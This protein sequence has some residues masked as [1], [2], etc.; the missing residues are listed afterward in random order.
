MTWFILL[1]FQTA[2]QSHSNPVY[3]SL[4]DHGM[5]EEA[6]DHLNSYPTKNMNEDDLLLFNLNK[7]EL[8]RMLG[9]RDSAA[10]YLHLGYSKLPP[11]ASKTK[12]NYL[13]ELCKLNRDHYNFKEAKKYGYE[14]L[15]LLPTLNDSSIYY[16][17]LMTFG[18]VF[19]YEGLL[20]STLVYYLKAEEHINEKNYE[21]RAILA[22]NLGNLLAEQEAYKSSF[23]KFSEAENLFS[24]ADN[25]VKKLHATI[26]KIYPLIELGR[27]EEAENINSQAIRTTEK[28]KWED[29]RIIVLNQRTLILSKKHNIPELMFIRDTLNE[30]EHRLYGRQVMELEEQYQ[31]ERLEKQNLSLSLKS[32][33]RKRNNLILLSIL[34]VG[35]LLGF[36]YV[37]NLR[38]KNKLD[39]AEG[40]LKRQIA[41]EAERNR[42]AGEMHDDLGGGLTTIKFLNDRLKRRLNESKDIE[43]TE[44]IGNHSQKL[45]TNMSEIIWAMNSKFDD[46]ESTIAYFRRVSKE[47]MSDVN[48]PLEFIQ[49]DQIEQKSLSSLLRRN[50]LL[51]MK[52][53]LHNV[54]KHSEA[55]KV[56]IEFSQ[57][58]ESL[59]MTIVD[60]GKGIQK[61]NAFGN[62]L[63]NMKERIEA[64]GAEFNLINS[65]A[66]VSICIKLFTSS[67][68]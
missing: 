58:E 33:Q 6:R 12:L 37:R 47:Y 11:L 49:P 22:N 7:G 19:S 48:I 1:F 10:Y 31:N 57:D 9:K 36:M 66:G 32:E 34:S 59:L 56:T 13:L 29:L 18:N 20:D 41:L 17:T 30:L 39:L 65:E 28:N 55:T 62:G 42:I 4:M 38:I 64:L 24:I 40:E 43:L 51:V 15:A 3:D 2:F 35:L 26:N 50:L 63:Q 46:L 52:E 21:Q 45:I 44:K 60:N 14:A 5:Y 23:E 68:L 53:A 27:W 8:F 16:K 61:E 67:N 25:E 54:V